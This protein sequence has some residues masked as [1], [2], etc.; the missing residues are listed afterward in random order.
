M[1]AAHAEMG[2]TE[3]VTRDSARTRRYALAGLSVL[4]TLAVK[5]V[6]NPVPTLLIPL[7]VS[8][9]G[10]TVTSYFG[11]RGPALFAAVAN[12]AVDWYFFAEPAFS[13]AIVNRWDVWLLAG[14]AVLSLAISL[15]GHRLSGTRHFPRV[16]L[17]LASCLLLLVVSALVWFDLE[18]S[19]E[20][21]RLVEHTYQVLNAS[22]ELFGT[23]QDAEGRQRNF[24]LTGDA[25]YPELYRTALSSE[26][27]A[28]R[29][30]AYLTNDNPL[31][32]AR[33]QKLDRLI[34][35]RL[36]LLERTIAVRREQG[37]QGAIEIVRG[38]QGSGLMDQIR[39][40]L[41]QMKAEE[42]RLLELRT[43][44]AA[45]QAARTRWVLAGGTVLLVVLLILSGAIIESELIKL[46]ASETL[47]RRQADLLNRAQGP[48]IVWELGGP[49]EYWNHAAE[50]LYGVDRAEALGRSHNDLL[51]PIHPLGMP[52][53][54]DLLVRD[55]QW[56]GE[57]M[58]WIDG[59]EVV[60]ESRMTLVTEEDGRRTVLKVNR[61]VTEEKRAQAEIRQLNQDLERR[62]KE[63]TAQLEASN[64]EL[65]AFAYS[66][67]HDLRAPLRGI[68]GWSMALLEDYGPRLDPPAQQYLD[69]VRAETQRMGALIDDLLQL[70]RLTRVEMRRE[71]VDLSSLAR[72]IACRL[73]EDQANRKIDFAIEEG[74]Q[75]EGDGHLLEIMLS[76]LLSNAVKF[77]GTRAEARIEFGQNWR[78]DQFA[79]HVRD[80]GVG[81]D[82]AYAGSLFGAFQRLH[83][84]SEFPGTGI[85]LAIAQRVLLRHGGRIWA[86]ARPQGG[87]TFYFTIG[88]ESSR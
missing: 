14:F 15:L 80:N 7:L 69:R 30:L 50:E 52:A 45:A 51:H 24:L 12:V 26:Q 56:Q 10:V 62:V 33:L 61:D 70:S 75:T 20:A 71:P 11:G 85:G 47:L 32:R 74:L 42:H 66:V 17:T 44:S 72:S 3:G 67:S 35:A 48:I 79:Y 58:Y 22:E 87:A 77:S 84:Q 43:G 83:K 54:Q 88:P 18:N 13:F 49:I 25:K 4:A 63:R 28:W 73:R 64:K 8:L 21:E 19:R 65:E 82:M 53:I 60:V 68:D 2:A 38:G 81:F 36:A 16:A 27:A 9:I 5:V 34:E 86:D 29:Q 46:K 23:I 76:N 39:A 31:Q 59:R 78:G 55:G 40:T 6:L 57:L 41:D 37:V 1:P